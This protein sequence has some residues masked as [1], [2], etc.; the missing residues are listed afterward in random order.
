MRPIFFQRWLM[1]LAQR[2]TQLQNIPQKWPTWCL[3]QFAPP[4]PAP[5]KKSL[6]VLT[7]RPVRLHVHFV[8]WLHENV[9][10]APT[11]PTNT[12]H[13]DGRHVRCKASWTAAVRQHTSV[14]SQR[15]EKCAEWLASVPQTLWLRIR[16]V[17]TS[18]FM[19]PS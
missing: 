11:N 16:V 13:K 14:M 15:V 3:M 12:F 5:P 2:R 9:L 4:P 7:C 10:S 8:R 19:R 18:R 1:F 17:I 6:A